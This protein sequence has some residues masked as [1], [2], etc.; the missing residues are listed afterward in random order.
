MQRL[1]MAETSRFVYLLANP[2]IPR[3]TRFFPSLATA[4]VEVLPHRDLFFV[5]SDVA[6]R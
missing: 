2:R 1:D 6:F 3:L 5:D 4:F